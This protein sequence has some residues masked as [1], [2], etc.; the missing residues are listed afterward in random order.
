MEE[1]IT[2]RRNDGSW[3]GRGAA[4]VKVGALLTVLSVIGFAGT[5]LPG[6][7]EATIGQAST[8]AFSAT[9]TDATPYFPSQYQ[10]NAPEPGEPAPTF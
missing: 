6:H 10:L 8:T 1:R 9:A 5:H 2:N 4:V 3:E 7:D